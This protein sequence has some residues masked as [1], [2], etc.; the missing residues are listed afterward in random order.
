MKKL[1]IAAVALCAAV[2]ANAS[3]VNWNYSNY[4]FDGTGG[5]GRTGTKEQ[6][7]YF[8]D[9]STYSRTQ[10]LTALNAKGGTTGF[11][12]ILANNKLYSN[13]LTTGSKFINN[14]YTDANSNVS[15]DKLTSYF[16]VIAGDSVFLSDEISGNGVT[17]G[18]AT[19][20]D[21]DYTTT[22][23]S[24]MS[25]STVRFDAAAGVASGNGGAGWY[26]VVP[27]P[28][29]GLLLLLGMAGLALRRRR[30]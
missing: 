12:T 16:A 5:N 2:A 29:S 24:P 19:T 8:F 3:T 6:T 27:E 9:A 10:L 30:A 26:T 11:D 13:S 25:K 14:S 22:N 28:T 18:S 21:I 20:Y 17:V 1:M 15:A 7:V 23:I 4:V